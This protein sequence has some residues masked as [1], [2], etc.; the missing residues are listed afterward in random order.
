MKALDNLV[1]TV[2]KLRGPNGC[3]W[4]KEQ[5]FETLRVCIIE[6]AYELVDAI[7]IK[8][9]SK[10]IEEL[11]DYLLQVIMICTIATETNLFYLEDVI[12]QVNQ[13]MINRHPHVF[14]QVTKLNSNDVIKQWEKIKEKELSSSSMMDSIASLPA[15]LKAEKIQ[16]RATK[17]KF[18]WPEVAG[19]L[20]K[21]EEEIEEFKIAL[22]EN[23]SN[24]HIEEEAGDI[25][26]SLVNVF[27]KCNINS[28]DALR[29]SNLKFIKRFKEMEQLAEYKLNDLSLAQQE[30]FWEKAKQ[31]LSKFK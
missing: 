5:T 1:S 25:L 12:N 7:E 10:I 6:E 9:N 19:A 24:N 26:F 15:L 31:N 4:D 29:K 20:S 22:K 13:K 30:E 8:N 18:D 21:L 11:G 2:E 3:E 17:V 28:E 14:K 16:K 23:N 27:R